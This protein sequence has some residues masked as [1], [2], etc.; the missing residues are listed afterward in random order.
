V[1]RLAGGRSGAA[2][3]YCLGRGVGWQDVVVYYGSQ[4]VLS[5]EEEVNCNE[6][7]DN[8][9]SICATIKRCVSKSVVT[10]ALEIC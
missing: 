7:S 2:C 6:T 4:N 8:G 5:A 9:Y 3:A 10:K 1:I